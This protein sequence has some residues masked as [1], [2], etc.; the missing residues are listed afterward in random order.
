MAYK[1]TTKIKWYLSNNHKIFSIKLMQKIIIS[2]I[3]RHLNYTTT[4]CPTFVIFL[5]V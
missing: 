1:L 3:I 5:E 2:K 4:G